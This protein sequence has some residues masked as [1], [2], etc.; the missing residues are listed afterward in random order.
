MSAQKLSSL[1]LA[2]ALAFVLVYF[3]V[4][5]LVA[6]WFAGTIVSF[7][8]LSLSSNLGLTT[9]IIGAALYISFELF[10]L[11][12]SRPPPVMTIMLAVITLPLTISR[13]IA[14]ISKEFDRIQELLAD[15]PS[16][17]SHI[18]PHWA[19]V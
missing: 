7:S 16:V 18:V 11:F 9:T 13:G 1:A 5:V 6:I 19:K 3:G 4:V 14:T 2:G 10:T 17:L 12:N 15:I 8:G